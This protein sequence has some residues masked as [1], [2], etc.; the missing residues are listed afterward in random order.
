MELLDSCWGWMGE[1]VDVEKSGE[2]VVATLPYVFVLNKSKRHKVYIKKDNGKWQFSDRGRVVGKRAS[3]KIKKQS[4]QEKVD[5]FGF[6]LLNNTLCC[7]IEF[8]KRATIRLN[9]FMEAM[10]R[11]D[12]LLSEWV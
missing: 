3:S 9:I 11:I 6:N 5:F 1:H 7:E 10:L 4:V 2:W 8:G 12:S